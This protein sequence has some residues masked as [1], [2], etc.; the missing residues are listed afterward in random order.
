MNEIPRSKIMKKSLHNTLLILILIMGLVAGCSGGK[1]DPT[2]PLP[3]DPHGQQ[4]NPNLASITGRVV[5]LEGTPCGGV[6]VD[7]QLFDEQMN[8]LSAVFNP[9]ET[10]P[11]TG[12]FQFLN[13]SLGRTIILKIETSNATIGRLIGY[14]RI[15]FFNSP[16][17]VDLGD[18]VMSNEQLELGWANYG[19]KQYNLALYHFRRALNTRYADR[20]TQS[21]SAFT[22][23][24]W[25]YA[26]RGRD[27]SGGPIYN[28][29]YEWYDAIA[30]F[31]T[32]KANPNDADAMVGL[33]GCYM[34]LVGTSV[35]LEPN[36]YDNEM[37]FYGYINPYMDEAVA[38][39]NQALAV[40]PEYE[41][42]HDI[43]H[44]DDLR[45]CVLYNRYLT[46]QTIT[47][48]EITELVVKPD[49]NVGSLQLLTDLA[50]LIE[51]DTQP[52]L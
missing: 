25:V 26:K 19:V 14:D 5:D 32:A 43:I 38:A 44:A 37:F 30:Q 33:A 41:C 29:G 35:L 28:R 52:Q 18:C 34:T 24:G 9:P 16:E 45:A 7:A 11:L 10:G 20:L 15:F 21:S 47:Q 46:G 4:G 39:L 6:F 40:A 2:Q 23:I 31:N 12:E 50:D 51:F 3:S 36:Q 49:L 8:P 48:N 22:G 42:S 13:L 17:H 1:T 27:M